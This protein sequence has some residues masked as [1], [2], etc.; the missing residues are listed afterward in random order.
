[1]FGTL[2][3]LRSVDA[4]AKAPFCYGVNIHPWHQVTLLCVPTP[5]ERAG[6]TVTAD[7]FALP[8]IYRQVHF[9]FVE[10]EKARMLG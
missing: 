6:H 3:R 1:M 8:P 4:L 2:P 7:Q 10:R 9:L 5:I